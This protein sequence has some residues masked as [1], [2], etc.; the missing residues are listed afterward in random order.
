[1]TTHA[2]NSLLMDYKNNAIHTLANIHISLSADSFILIDKHLCTILLLPSLFSPE[3]KKNSNSTTALT[4]IV[5]AFMY[6]LMKLCTNACYIL[7]FSFDKSSALSFFDSFNLSIRISSPSAVFCELAKKKKCCMECFAHSVYVVHIQFTWLIVYK[8]E[9]FS[10]QCKPIDFFHRLVRSFKAFLP[11][12]N[13]P[14]NSFVLRFEK[15]E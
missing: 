5:T 3:V 7:L 14:L 1:M 13:V 12:Y 9:R 10:K 4:H 15:S 11:S 6:Q 8:R 2:W